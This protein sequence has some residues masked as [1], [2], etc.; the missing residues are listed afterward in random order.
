[1][2]VDSETFSDSRLPSR[3]EVILPA[4][5]CSA[6]PK[7][8]GAELRP[9]LPRAASAPKSFQADAQEDDICFLLPS[10]VQRAGD[11]KCEVN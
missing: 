1:M 2:S 10:V 4:T 6:R 8:G 9:S 7:P 11:E 3:N 5:A